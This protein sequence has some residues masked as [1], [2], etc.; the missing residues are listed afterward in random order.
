MGQAGA[1]TVEADDEEEP[2]VVTAPVPEQRV[3]HG[4][5]ILVVSVKNYRIAGTVVSR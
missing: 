3:V 5:G 2:I 4:G 1:Y